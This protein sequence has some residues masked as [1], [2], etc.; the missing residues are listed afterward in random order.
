MA[1]SSGLGKG[2]SSIIPSSEVPEV[3]DEPAGAHLS[4]VPIEAVTPNPNQPRVHFDEES[5]ARVIRT[6]V[7]PG[8]NRLDQSMPMYQMPEGDMADL[9]AYMKRLETDFDPG[10]SDDRIQVGTLLPLQGSQ[11]ELGRAMAQA[12]H[13]HFQQLNE[14]G[15]IFGRKLELLA[16]PYGSSAGATLDNL[17]AAFENEGVF[18]LVGASHKLDFLHEVY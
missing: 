2:L 1:R 12:I 9:I 4:D 13:A 18:A 6:G 14:K 5:L 10:L 7:D 15:G 17:R 11:G 3:G 16:V 8:E